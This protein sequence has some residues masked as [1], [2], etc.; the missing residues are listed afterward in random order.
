MENE[1]SKSGGTG[2]GSQGWSEGGPVESLS[3]GVARAEIKAIEGDQNFAGDG[4]MD[5]WS[6]QKMLRRRSDL[7][8]H[9]AGSEGERPYNSMEQTLRQQG[10]TEKTVGEAKGKLQDYVDELHQKRTEK[11][12]QEKWENNTE[13]EIEFVQDFVIKNASPEFLDYLDESRLG[14]NPNVIFFAHGLA[15]LVKAYPDAS[16]IIPALEKSVREYAQGVERKK[17]KSELTRRGGGK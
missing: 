10:I 7:Y 17:E 15:N 12:L 8:K 6:R 11:V 13:K 2:G 3:S 14:D 16:F 1:S 5:Y 4:K 9:A